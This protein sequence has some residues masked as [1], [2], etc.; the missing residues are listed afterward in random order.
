VSS[1]IV[2]VVASRFL[3]RRFPAAGVVSLCVLCVLCASVVNTTHAKLTTET[4]RA[5]RWHREFSALD[6]SLQGPE[7]DYANF[8]HSSQRHASLACTACHQRKD[9]SA[10]PLFPGHKA[11]ISCHTG[12]FVTANVPMCVICHTDV[13]GSNPPLKSFPAKFNDSFNVKFDHAQH[14]S[15][16]ARPASGCAACHSRSGGRAAALGI[17]AGIAA[18]NQCYTCHTPS[19]KSQS[20][21][22]LASCGVCHDQKAF[23]RTTTNARAFRFAFSHARH[24]SGQRLACADCH[25]LTAGLPQSRQVS[26]PLP[27][28]HFASGGR[29]CLSCH[30]GQRSFG[31]DLA[32][33]ECRRCHTSASF[34]MPL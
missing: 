23:V 18:H 13:N 5:Q 11:C 30:N 29:T 26:S 32:F 2:K 12:Q 22:D 21:H 33:K 4:Q 19:S 28:E 16:S 15:G 10:T 24:G 20:G 14:M 25:S 31:G 7:L 9:N 34:K 8:K 1:L 27:L 3:L 6:N 17:P